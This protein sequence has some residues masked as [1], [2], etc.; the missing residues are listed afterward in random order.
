MPFVDRLLTIVVTA[1]LTSAAWLVAGGVMT[2]KAG[3]ASGVATGGGAQP[4]SETSPA[5]PETTL[6]APLRSGT[7]RP[8]AAT[9]EGIGGLVMP[10]SGVVA[11]SLVDTYTQARDGGA[12]LHD[13]IDIMAPRGTTVVSAAPGKVEKLFLSNAGGQTIYVR[14]ADGTTIYYYAHLDSYAPGLVEGQQVAAGTPLGTVGS[15][16][17]ASP[18]GPHL[19]FAIMRTT[20]QA[21]WWDDATAINPYPL[22]GGR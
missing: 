12:R 16:G 15:T 3:I 17:N 22:L 11:S 7:A 21:K 20:P 8:V 9:S 19:H 14:S 6:P 10:V 13:A 1:T 5:G 2:E 18:D 4:P